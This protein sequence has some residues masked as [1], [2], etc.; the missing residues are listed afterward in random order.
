MNNMVNITSPTSIYSWKIIKT[1]LY[2]LAYDLK[3]MFH[4]MESLVELEST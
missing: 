3:I 4:I 2:S 1:L